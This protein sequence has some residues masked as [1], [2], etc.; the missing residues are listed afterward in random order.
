PDARIS[1]A[2]CA[3]PTLPCTATSANITLIA[4]PATSG[5]N[6]A[7]AGQGG[8]VHLDP[9][10]LGARYLLFQ[11]PR[12]PYVFIP[13]ETQLAS[14]RGGRPGHGPGTS[15]PCPRAGRP[16]R[17]PQTDARGHARRAGLR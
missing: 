10:R 12:R 8:A 16:R 15:G 17:P 13:A 7:L 11:L 5:P 2:R 9:P 3:P 14:G 1:I 4:E 6:K